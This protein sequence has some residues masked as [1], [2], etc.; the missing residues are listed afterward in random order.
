MIRNQNTAPCKPGSFFYEPYPES[1]SGFFFLPAV[2]SGIGANESL[3]FSLKSVIQY[4][5]G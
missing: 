3:L 1:L 5:A 2:A 4:A